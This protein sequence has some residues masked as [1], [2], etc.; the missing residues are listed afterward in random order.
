MTYGKHW[1]TRNACAAL[2]AGAVFTPGSLLAADPKP[3]P[4]PAAHPAASAHPPAK[5]D[6]SHGAAG[7]AA[8]GHGPAT[9]G[10][11]DRGFEAANLPEWIAIG[12][13]YRGK[14][15]FP[16][17]DFNKTRD[18]NYYLSRLRLETTINPASWVRLHAQA[19]DSQILGYRSRTKPASYQNTLDLRQGYVDLGP[20]GE[21]G[22]N[23]RIGRQ[24]LSYG[25]E[26]LV[27]TNDWNNVA[28][29]FDAVRVSG[30]KPGLRVDAFA[31]VPVQP[32]QLRFDRHFPG[33]RFF[34][35]HVVLDTLLPATSI[36][37]YFLWKSLARV[38]G[39][40][41]TSGFA[42]I[43]TTGVRLTGMLRPTLHYTAEL[44][45]QFGSYAG[46]AVSGRAGSV[47]MSWTVRDTPRKPR[48]SFEY[49]YASGDGNPADGRRGTFDNLYPSNHDYYGITDKVAW[50]N[51]HNPHVGFDFHATHSLHLIAEYH[52]FFLATRQDGLYNYLGERIVLNRLATSSYVGRELN[53]QAH[54]TVNGK[55]TLGAGLG[56]MTRGAYLRQSTTR[57]T[58][59][60]YPYVSFYVHP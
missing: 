15:E 45:G 7:H 19:Q 9:T 46:N 37:P 24:E 41:A 6:T 11:A 52:E 31:S 2:L 55:V 48:L 14:A 8:P 20:T 36:E 27:G 16:K 60:W 43:D 12:A 53:A 26:R 56:H 23:V 40:G 42:N 49:S 59:Y 21:R 3:H 33:Q 18:D 28:R 32:T 25:G 30:F 5:Q 22:V 13:I 57:G 38:S 35:S 58:N 4:A 47:Q 50:Q 17:G 39:E 51:I 34:G 10:R 29:S 44:A 1:V 54:W